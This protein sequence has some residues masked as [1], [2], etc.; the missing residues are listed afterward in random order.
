[1]L[2]SPE[3]LRSGVLMGRRRRP[4]VEALLPELMMPEEGSCRSDIAGRGPEETGTGSFG[5]WG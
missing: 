4:P 5:G 1:M 3:L 2:S